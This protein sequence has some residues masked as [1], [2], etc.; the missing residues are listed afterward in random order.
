MQKI[1][2]V[3]PAYNEAAT[4]TDLITKVEMVDLGAGLEKE[5]VIVNDGSK[6]NTWEVISNYKEDQKF[7]LLNNEQNLGK[8][9]TVRK[10]ILATTGDL[11]VIQDADL[12]YDPENLRQFVQLI[13]NGEADVV[14]GNRFGKQNKIIYIQNWIGNTFLSFVSA[15]FTGLR[16]GIWPRDMEVCYKMM[17]GEVF[18]DI[19]KQIT[20]T[21]RFGL[22]PEI[23]ARM[24]KY[25][26][27]DG[28]HLKFKQVPIDYYPRTIA[29]G[30]K[31]NAVSDGLKALW[32]IVKY[33]LFT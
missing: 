9:Q 6:D 31:M 1:S 29:A 13:L 33:N 5:I 8:S 23:T 21:S 20:A 32:E 30:K 16:A 15:I 17:Q 26:K 19:A 25:R 18:R 22:E 3:I 4:I 10:G 2:F 28:S 14:Y 7:K 27:A 11:V 24:A 12:E